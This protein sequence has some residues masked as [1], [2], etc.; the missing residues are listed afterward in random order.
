LAL[1]LVVA[2]L[3]IAEHGVAQTIDAAVLSSAYAAAADKCKKSVVSINVG[4]SKVTR[5]RLK[6]FEEHIA[7]SGGSIDPD[8]LPEGSVGSGVIVSNDGYILTNDHV[9]DDVDEDSILITL[10]DGRRYFADVVGSDPSSDLALLRIYAQNL[11]A[12]TIAKPESVRLGELVI[13][14]GSPLG[15]KFTV[16]SGVVSA[17]VRDDINDDGYSVTKYIQT[18]AAINPGNSG[19]GLFRIQ[20]DLV[21]INTAILSKT[22][23][24][25]GYGLALSTDLVEAVYA[26]LREDGKI[27]RPSLGVSARSESLDSALSIDRHS[28]DETVIIDKV[29]PGGA[30]DKAGLKV[31]DIVRSFNGLDVRTRDNITQHMALFRPGQT[32]T[33][34]LGRN[35]DTVSL[36][37]T[38]DTLELP[39]KQ[40]VR[41]MPRRPY[42]GMSLRSEGA[43]LLLDKVK[44]Y[45][46][47]DNAGL[48]DGDVVVSINGA[49]P[50]SPADFTRAV[51]STKPGDLLTIVCSRRDKKFTGTVVVGV[52]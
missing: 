25:I 2:F 3:L 30:A 29:K 43:A 39:F 5:K 14:I 44:R 48:L 7:R 32:I 50:T 22:G 13:A 9:V 8:A 41:D 42:I 21:G 16:T 47:A 46:P 19:G 17:L 28:V 34:S 49:T 18:D 20:G 45:G 11:Q 37:V 10:H 24:N 1:A 38:L 31:G 52:K 51:A 33:V 6:H 27:S 26:D 12:A 35:G 4:L 40:R 23:F 15:L 36:P